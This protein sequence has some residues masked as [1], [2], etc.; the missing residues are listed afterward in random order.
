MKP[1]KQPKAQ[2][3]VQ[4]E[5]LRRT[6]FKVGVSEAQIIKYL[7]G[8][9]SDKFRAILSEIGSNAL[10][11]NILA[12]KEGREIKPYEILLPTAEDPYLRIRDYGRGMDREFA[13]EN[14]TTYGLTTKDGDNVQ[15]GGKGIGS[16]APLG[17]GPFSIET[18]QGGFLT[19][20]QMLPD[21]GDGFPEGIETHYGETDEPDG[22]TVV[23]PVSPRD[24]SSFGRACREYLEYM[25]EHLRPECSTTIDYFWD[26]EGATDLRPDGIPIVYDKNASRDHYLS[27]DDKELT[28]IVGYRPYTV[29]YNALTDTIREPYNEILKYMSNPVFIFPVGY[30]SVSDNRETIELDNPT[31]DRL[32]KHFKEASLSIEE[33]FKK[34]VTEAE[35]F[36]EAYE[37]SQNLLRSMTV[38]RYGLGTQNIKFENPE[39]DAS[40][41][42][43]GSRD[44]IFRTLKDE[45]TNLKCRDVYLKDSDLARWDISCRVHVDSPCSFTFR[46]DYFG[47]SM[48]KEGKLP[49]FYCDPTKVKD[50]K[51]RLR[52]YFS[53]DGL[54]ELDHGFPVYVVYTY[55]SYKCYRVFFEDP[56]ILVE[57]CPE[58]FEVIKL[59]DVEAP[60]LTSSVNDREYFDTEDEVLSLLNN[61]TSATCFKITSTSYTK[62]QSSIDA[63]ETYNNVYYYPCK[64]YGVFEVLREDTMEPVGSMEH[65]RYERM[66]ARIVETLRIAGALKKDDVVLPINITSSQKAWFKKMKKDKDI[67]NILSLYKKYIQHKYKDG[68]PTLN[69]KYNAKIYDWKDTAR[70][71]KWDLQGSLYA[72]YFENLHSRMDGAYNYYKDKV[73][74]LP[75]I[76]LRDYFLRTKAIRSVEIDLSSYEGLFGEMKHVEILDSGDDMQKLLCKELLGIPENTPE[77]PEEEVTEEPEETEEE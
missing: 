33:Y 64:G 57:Q 59:E 23:I 14:Y 40:E 32:E 67:I 17:Y 70:S 49:I 11:E 58:N 4:A 7:T 29:R 24:F 72:E 13:N 1:L 39:K 50:W 55:G 74:K 2:V 44:I 20:I 8:L 48:R 43:V 18:R 62:V 76:F 10:D 42:Q 38:G 5:G 69:N 22:T 26:R 54:E 47:A 41:I 28:F 51:V 35:T 12:K 15:I 34:A 61:T 73:G 65:G 56:S 77:P 46:R 37:A 52:Y 45:E 9:Y 27:D 36:Y 21:D 19:I 16:K 3:E 60:K 63:V 53:D 6:K 25:P 31:L 66:L 71:L 75:D 30:L 68:L